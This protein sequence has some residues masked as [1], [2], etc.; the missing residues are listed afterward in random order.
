M[1]K[2]NIVLW[3]PVICRLN[4]S[5]ENPK[6][7]S[8]NRD[9]KGI[10]YYDFSHFLKYFQHLTFGIT[11]HCI[12]VKNY[13]K[14]LHFKCTHKELIA[15]NMFKYNIV[16]WSHVICRLNHSCEN[17]KWFRDNREEKAS[18]IT[19]FLIFLKY[20]QHLTFG[21]TLHCISGKSTRR[22]FILNA[23]IKNSSPLTCLS[24][25]L[26]CEVTWYVAWT[27]HVK[28]LND[29][30]TIVTEKASSITIFLIF[31]IFS[32]PHVWNNS[33][34]HFRKNYE[35]KLH[36]KCTH[37]ELIAL[38]MFKYNIVLWS[39]V[40]C[41]LNHSCENPKWFRDNR[42]QKVSSIT[43]FLIFFYIFNTSR[44][45]WLSIAFQ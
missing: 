11:L 30:G 18:S 41:R 38:N 7:F 17:P 8:D 23:H 22:N 33:P 6:W 10:K 12:S 37:K 9:G 19:I 31:L 36:F 13:E 25:I 29:S 24:I 32:T 34:L 16:L 28:I 5:C 44:F 27:I 20:F 43:I 4:H 45:E 1:F 21:I 3:S 14:K 39:H 40:I 35:K 26:C 15:L 2:Y 42:E